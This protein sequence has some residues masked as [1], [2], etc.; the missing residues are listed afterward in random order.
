MGLSD[1]DIIYINAAKE[2]IEK[3]L[4][5]HYTIPEIAK[6]IGTNESKLKKGFK[7]KFGMGI[8]EFLTNVRME[9]ARSLLAEDRK[10]LKQ[11][12]RHVGYK[13]I[14]NFITAFE[15]KYNQSPT[16]FKKHKEV[17]SKPKENEE[18]TAENFS[19]TDSSKM[20]AIFILALLQ[21]ALCN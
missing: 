15:K 20:I 3:H 8:F 5:R 7:Q 14:S 4:D 17:N 10:S 1:Y 16:D 19:L 12:A 9:K 13:H 6:E 18:A 2:L 11:I 21:F